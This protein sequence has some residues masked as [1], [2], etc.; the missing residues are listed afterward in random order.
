[1]TTDYTTFAQRLETA[2]EWPCTYTFKFI[3]PAQEAVLVQELFGPEASLRKV[4]SRTGKYIS[5]TAETMMVS[6]EQ[7]I[8]IYK[9]AASIQG[10]VML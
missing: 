9:Q 6:T 7:V 2:H 3:V 4:A 8:D 10:I 1:M 5:V